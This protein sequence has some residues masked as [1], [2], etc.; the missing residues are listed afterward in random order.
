[1]KLK[2]D[3]IILKKKLFGGYDAFYKADTLHKF[4]D[5]IQYIIYHGDMATK[6][7]KN[8]IIQPM[9]K[10]QPLEVEYIEKANKLVIDTMY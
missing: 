8:I 9:M 5:N 7:D 10:E 6:I 3:K 4:A 2:T 1:M